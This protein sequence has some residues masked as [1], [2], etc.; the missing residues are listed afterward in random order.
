MTLLPPESGRLRRRRTI[1]QSKITP[2][3]A[4]VLALHYQNET[5]HPQGR[6]RV[7]IAEANPERAAIIAAARRLIE[8]ARARAV[9]VISV[10]IAFPPDY[11][12]VAENAEIFRRVVASRAMAEGSWGA[13]FHD[14]LGPLPD[15]LVVTHQRNNPFHGSALADT[16][17]LFR[18]ERLIMAGI[19]TTYVVESA[20][21]HAVDMGY[22]VMVAA[23]ACSSATRAMHES[24][25]AAMA[26]LAT[27]LPV[28]DILAG[29]DRR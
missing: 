22:E 16:V 2:A 19:S 24:S 12:G 10:R 8:G 14:G 18:P 9:P 26:L 17:A 4:I 25:L 29:L 28:D 7:G 5:V 13:E 20:V 11:R 21:R 3:P 23:D 1:T 15:E 6:I 27:V